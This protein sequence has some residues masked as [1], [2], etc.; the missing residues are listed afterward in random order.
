M[1]IR[2][3]EYSISELVDKVNSIYGAALKRPMSGRM[4]RFLITEGIVSKPEGQT[5]AA[6][7]ND[8]HLM[9]VL[10]YYRLKEEGMTVS[11]IANRKEA[12]ELVNGI[13]LVI[14]K[15]INPSNIDENEVISKL[16]TII[17]MLKTNKGD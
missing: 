15:N 10:N 4:L 1:E 8:N 9:Q 7:Y 3:M 16:K 5:S 17:R 2:R 11:Q 14:S 6:K 13:T 12:I